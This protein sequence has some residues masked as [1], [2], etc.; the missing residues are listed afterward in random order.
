[1]RA[2]ERFIV[3]PVEKSNSSGV[4][5][6]IDADFV[7]QS[8]REAWWRAGEQISS[9]RNHRIRFQSPGAAEVDWTRS[10]LAGAA[11]DRYRHGAV[12]MSISRRPA[13]GI[14]AQNEHQTGRIHGIGDV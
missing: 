8:S 4:S 2:I 12:Q 9:C 3:T 10:M 1:M 6:W 13:L 14:G 7:R 5:E 11:V